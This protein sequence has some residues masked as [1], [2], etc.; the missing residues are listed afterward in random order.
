MKTWSVALPI[1]GIAYIEVQA[2]DEASA[3]EAALNSDAL[4]IESIETWEAHQYILQGNVFY[5]VQNEAEAT[6]EEDDEEV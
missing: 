6:L 3:I 4:T 2:E 5:G 1:T